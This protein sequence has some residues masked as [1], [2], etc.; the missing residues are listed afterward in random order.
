MHGEEKFHT[1]A[2]GSYRLVINR[3]ERKVKKAKSLI[4]KIIDTPRFKQEVQN[5]MKREDGT[6]K[7]K[8][9]DFEDKIKDVV[10]SIELGKNLEGK[11]RFCP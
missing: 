8:R 5:L 4:D 6:Y 7:V 2:W 3:D 9:G 1:L 10:K 11:C